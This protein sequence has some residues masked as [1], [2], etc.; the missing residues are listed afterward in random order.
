MGDEDKTRESL[1][2]E[3]GEL[4]Q[5]VA[6][7]EA[8]ETKRKRAEEALRDSEEKYRP[9]AESLPDLVYEF[10]LEGNFFYVNEAVTHLFGYSKDEILSDIRVQDTIVEE[11]RVHLRNSINDILK[12]K[13]TVGERT[14][15]RKDG[16]KFIGE[17]HS[18]PVYRGKDVVGIRGILRDITERKGVQEALYKSEKRFRDL[19]DLLPEAVYEIDL[20][21]NFTFANQRAF[22]LSGY[23]REDF[24]GGLNALQMFIPEDRG[25]VRENINKILAGE[26]LGFMEYTAQRKD[27]STF[28]V[29]IHSAAIVHESKLVGLRGIIID[30]SGPKKVQEEIE[31]ER[32]KFETY[33]ES[34]VDGICVTEK[35]GAIV[36]VNEA[37]ITMFGYK[38]SEEMIGRTIFENVSE[39]EIPRMTKRFKETVRKKESG[40]RDFEVIC[41]RKDRSEFPVSFNIRN[42]W[43]NG[44]YVGSISVARDITER[45][46]AEDALREREAE[47]VIKTD[48][49]K[50]VNTALG[51]LLKKRD[52][53]KTE[54]EK[55]VVANVKEL[56]VPFLKK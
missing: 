8:S 47:L 31:A 35:S 18:G 30:I 46:Q 49:L 40:I 5:R 6:E 36:Q 21:G 3:L 17:I 37:L 48:S 27:G 16:S 2:E 25:K 41:L 29:D 24:E 13:T 44:K 34:M 20:D 28:P 45:K 11:D 14:L 51:V 7:L 22:Q 23:S 55:K 54:L 1:I 50:E 56:V 15:I 26:D 43:E 38:S 19:A 32:K 9:L 10:D 52:E 33:I 4:R 53:D 12:G 39:R 42:L